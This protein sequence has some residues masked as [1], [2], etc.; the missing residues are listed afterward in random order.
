MNGLDLIIQ[1]SV[2]AKILRT[3]NPQSVNPR[4]DKGVVIGF[5]VAFFLH[6]TDNVMGERELLGI[7]GM[8]WTV[9]PVAEGT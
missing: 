8:P 2:A 6:S 5:P 4:K 7:H 9:S 3:I 1:C